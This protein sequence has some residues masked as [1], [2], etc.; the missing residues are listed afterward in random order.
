M[1]LGNKLNS[2]K[3][4]YMFEKNKKVSIIFWKE[5]RCLKFEKLKKQKIVPDMRHA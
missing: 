3:T 1:K 2:S 5:T 4:A